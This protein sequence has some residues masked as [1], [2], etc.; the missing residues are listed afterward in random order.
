MLILCYVYL[1]CVAQIRNSV[2]WCL[3]TVFNWCLRIAISC[4]PDNFRPCK[5]F[6]RNYC[7]TY[8]LHDLY[9]VYH[10]RKILV[11][12]CYFFFVFIWENV[13]FLNAHTYIV[14]RPS[15]SR[16]LLQAVPRRLSSLELGSALACSLTAIS[17]CADVCQTIGQCL[18][19]IFFACI[20]FLEILLPI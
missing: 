18:H 8:T 6:C 2:N 1:S 16:Y 11:N 10:Q 5:S 9:S 20:L 4:L 17:I 3:R 15:L 19:P 13:L 14:S 7:Q 12:R